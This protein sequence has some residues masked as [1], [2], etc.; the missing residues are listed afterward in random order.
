MDEAIDTVCCIAD[1]ACTRR[2]YACSRLIRYA[3]FICLHI[4]AGLVGSCVVIGP[5]GIYFWKQDNW[6]KDSNWL[7]PIMAG[8]MLYFTI[9]L[10][11]VMF[12]VSSIRERR[13]HRLIPE[14]ESV[15]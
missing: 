4:I 9:L 14:E 15:L 12:C 5:I 11:A 1:N 7:L 6:S 13:M 10:A 8:A 2:A 3:C